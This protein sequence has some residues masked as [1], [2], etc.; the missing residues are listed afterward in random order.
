MKEKIK[1]VLSSKITVGVVCFFLGGIVM[2]NEQTTS[3]PIKETVVEQTEIETQTDIVDEPADKLMKMELGKDY[4]ITSNTGD[5]SIN[6]EGI[7]FTNDRNQFSD[8]EAKHVIFLDFNYSNISET[9]ETYVF[10]SHF[11]IIDEE[12]NI[13]DTYPVSDDNRSSKKLPI[14]AKCNSSAAYAMTTS[15][16]T[17]NVLFYDNMFGE[18]VGQT[19]IETG[20]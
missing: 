5:Y 8:K 14:G 18:P 6:I 16:K 10:D 2:S 9:E 7:R 4:T 20:L 11:K 1:K 15:S 12:G 13:L 17:L 3:S 19:T